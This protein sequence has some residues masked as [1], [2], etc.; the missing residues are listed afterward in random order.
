MG[1]RKTEVP[2]GLFHVK[3]S[4]SLALNT[5]VLVASVSN[6]F[7]KPAFCFLKELS[8]NPLMTRLGP[9]GFT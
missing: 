9:F 5:F 8:N 7:V 3:P 6:N 4:R 2:L 1:F